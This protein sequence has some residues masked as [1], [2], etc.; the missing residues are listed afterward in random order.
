MTT[1]E[2][3]P[4]QQPQQMMNSNQEITPEMRRKIQ[5]AMMKQ[6]MGG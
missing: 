4:T 6:G 2:A 3:P 1:Q 5:E